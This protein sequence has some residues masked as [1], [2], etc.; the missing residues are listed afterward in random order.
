MPITKIHGFQRGNQNFS[1]RGEQFVLTEECLVEAESPLDLI[2]NIV[3][4]LPN[5]ASGPGPTDYNPSQLTFT[6]KVSV[7][8]ESANYYLDSVNGMKRKDPDSNFWIIPLTYITPPVNNDRPQQ[9]KKPKSSK[10]KDK[11]RIS[12]PLERPPTFSMSIGTITEPTFTDRY[13]RA[14]CHRNKL[15]ITTPLQQYSDQFSMDW[16]WNISIS[17]VKN[18][19]AAASKFTNATNEDIFSIYNTGGTSV[20]MPFGRTVRGTGAKLQEVWETP[21]GA[22]QEYQYCRVGFSIVYTPSRMVDERQVSKHTLQLKNGKLIQIPTNAA[23]TKATQPWPLSSNGNALS[24]ED[25]AD[26]DLSSASYLIALPVE[27]SDLQ[28]ADADVEVNEW[29]EGSAWEAFMS[30][31]K[32]YIPGPRT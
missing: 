16:Q 10:Q 3:N 18:F 26:G 8:P 30:E 22:D 5:I 21:S 14:I 17:Q 15:P 29:I 19:L 24:Y 1:S 27:D 31:Y 2:S 28:V 20:L 7:H 25:V 13:Q 32:L 9:V 11:E 4:E 23:G 12:N 6:L